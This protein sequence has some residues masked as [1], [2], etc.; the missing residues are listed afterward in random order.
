M[1]QQT[2]SWVDGSGTVYGNVQRITAHADGSEVDTFFGC[3]LDI[4]QATPVLPAQVDT[5]HPDGPYQS[6]S[7]P[8]LSI[9][10]AILKY[11][12]QCLVAEVAFDPVTI[13]IGRDPSNW[14][15]LA[16]R[17][18]AWSDIGSATAV[19]TFDIRPTPAGLP[20][21]QMVD[22]LMIDWGSTPTRSIATI[23]LP[24]ASADEILSLASRMY[25][26]HGLTRVDDHTLRCHTGRITY[27]PLPSR[28]SGNYAG[29]LTVDPPSLHWHGNSF[30]VVVR[31]ITNAYVAVP[32]DTE[33]GGPPALEGG[34]GGNRYNYIQWRRVLGTFQLTAPV[35]PKESLLLT[36]ERTLAVLRWIAEAIPTASRWHPVFLR[37]LD[38]IAGRVKS[39][40]GNPSQIMPSP[41]GTVGNPG[42]GGEEHAVRTGKISGVVY[43]RFG[44]FEGFVLRTRHGKHEFHSREEEIEVLI[45]RAWRERLRLRVISERGEPHNV[46]SI[47]ILEPPVPFDKDD[48]EDND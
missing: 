39:F 3:W 20:V 13:P 38:I 30:T 12:H 40:G 41:T 36:E 48:E 2:D 43:D 29:L 47:V 16:Q 35:K 11:R 32:R 27:V 6:A 19:T 14:D 4:N 42:P 26:T 22:E 46:S 28:G 18:I 15:K 8:P 34:R 17:N 37:Y 44:D 24:A 5:L 9:Q 7:N 21:G 33:R 10:Q 1:S 31:Q 25:I 45:R 23:Y